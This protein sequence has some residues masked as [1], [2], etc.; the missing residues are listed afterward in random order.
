M[1]LKHLQ[2]Q[3]QKTAGRCGVSAWGKRQI[4]GTAAAGGEGPRAPAQLPNPTAVLPG[5]SLKLAHG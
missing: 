1:H 4:H 3:L 2:R 5:V